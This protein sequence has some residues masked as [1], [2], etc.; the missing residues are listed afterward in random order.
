MDGNKR[1]ITLEEI[2]QMDIVDYLAGLGFQ[3]QTVK[4]N[5]TDHWYLSPLRTEGEASFKVNQT[6]N[7]WFDFGLYKG[8]N[9]V[10]F[11]LLYFNCTIPELLDKFSQEKSAERLPVV[12]F[13]HH[14]GLAENEPLIRVLS[15]R[16]LF[17][18]PLKNLLYERGI[19][20]DL[21]AKFCCEVD[22]EMNGRRRYAIGF[23]NNSGGY[24]LRDPKFKR[25]SSPKD[26]TS[27]ENGADAVHIFEGFMDFLSW[28]TLHPEA[29]E[30]DFDFVVLN[31]AGLFERARPSLTKYTVKHLWLDRD[32]TGTAYSQYAL[33]LQEGFVDE[34]GLYQEHK[35][36]ND[37]LRLKMQGPKLLA[38]PELKPRNRL[39]HGL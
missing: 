9:L 35:D 30:Q 5:G 13:G 14:E 25:S 3:P 11:C 15:E 34:S 27:I 18:Y 20:V 12:H 7:R 29:L 4:K 37:Y 32:A 39:R 31:G 1:R 19:P 28:K 8:G 33:S 38:E 21:A 26:M 6:R 2:K 36:L 16:A 23:K 10:D 17:R 24:E 22:Y